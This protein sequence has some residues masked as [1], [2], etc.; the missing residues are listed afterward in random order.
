[1]ILLLGSYNTRPYPFLKGLEVISGSLTHLTISACFFVDLSDILQSCPNLVSLKADGIDPVMPSSPSERF[2]NITHLSLKDASKPYFTNEE[3]VDI[4]SRFP[5]L[6][7]L[8]LVFV[9]DSI[10]LPLLYELCPYL[11]ILYYGCLGDFDHAADYIFPEGKGITMA[12]LRRS[13]NFYQ[14]DL[15]KFLFLY[16]HSLE[17]LYIDGTI[18]M[19]DHALW[20]ISNGRL[21]P[22]RN[23]QPLE[24]DPRQSEPLFKELLDFCFMKFAT[25]FDI[26]FV[27][28][29]LLNVPNLDSVELDEAFFQP[30]ISIAM[31]RLRH[32]SKLEIN[33]AVGAS[34][35]V[36]TSIKQFL[37]HHIALRD[38]SRLKHIIVNTG[39]CMSK[40]D[41]IPL[42]AR[43]KGLKKLELNVGTMTRTCSSILE[44]IGYGCPVL[45][46]L[47]LTTDDKKLHQGL[48]APLRQFP[49]L[50]RFAIGVH[51]ISNADLHFLASLGS[52][53]R[54]Y[55]KTNV[56]DD[57]LALLKSR[58]PMVLA[59]CR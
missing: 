52:L 4:L 9:N 54:L 57:I 56:P 40:V 43:F 50:K 29:S 14:D 42:L 3:I 51:T 33:F 15:I 46:E 16:R 59:R 58:I 25:P 45:D 8:E 10:V 22:R 2:P 47:W 53:E 19:D 27:Q 13:E 12:H 31:M 34:G 32:L 21:E 23:L 6:I 30:D 24:L 1:M 36:N 11:K 5:S 38:D 28:W 26:S 49:S 41:W 17:E 55:L 39:R 44:D 48:L 37:E 35:N 20:K 7:W 18:M